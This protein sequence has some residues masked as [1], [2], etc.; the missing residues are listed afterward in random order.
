M[1]EPKE[2]ICAKALDLGFNDIG[3]APPDPGDLA[4]EHLAAYLAQGRHGAMEWME[5][6]ALLRG[7][8]T[9]LM[10]NAR[11]AIVLAMNYGPGAGVPVDSAQPGEGDIALYARGKDY[12]DV[13]KPRLKAL[14]RWMAESF[15]CDIKVFVD[16][17]PLM[18]KRL[19]ALAGLGWQGK[20]TN[21]VSRRFG[22]WL[23]LGVVL[24]SLD[25]PFDRPQADHCGS[26][27]RCLAACPTGAITPYRMDARRCISYLTIEHKEE[28]APPLARQMGNRVFGC[29]ACLAVCP[30]NRFAKPT[31]H[32]SLAP[33]PLPRSLEEL[34]A[35]DD[36]AFRSAFAQTPVKRTGHA[37]FQRNVRIAQAN[38]L[39][40]LAI[41]K[42]DA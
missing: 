7:N 23:F 28:I 30:W 40:P 31:A 42:R 33:R 37:R 25:L 12:H 6:R 35:Q 1:N 26:C 27:D 4:R 36:A 19:A 2:Q 17:A 29:D 21:L 5:T 13:M 11:T 9:L 34:A 22:S 8:P 32:A 24:T 39:R 14:G 18:E 41:R 38:E 20:H 15:G 16:T 3:F 10:P